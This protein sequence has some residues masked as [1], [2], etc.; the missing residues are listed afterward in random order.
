MIVPIEN[1][2]PIYSLSPSVGNILNQKMF[3]TILIGD[4]S[5]RSCWKKDVVQ[6]GTT[7][8]ARHHLA[9]YVRTI[10]GEDKGGLPAT[11]WCR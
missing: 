6:K 10:N 9:S 1:T 11:G 3:L 5:H 7:L 4:T 8:C 2:F